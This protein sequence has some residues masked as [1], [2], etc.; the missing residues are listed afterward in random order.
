MLRTFHPLIQQLSRAGWVRHVRQN[1][2][3][4]SVIG[5]ADELEQF[6]FGSSRAALSEAASALSKIQSRKCFYCGESIG[7]GGDVDHFIPWAKYPRDLAHNFVLAHAS[8]NRHKSD[9]LAAEQHLSRW[10]DRN[11]RQGED[12]V[13][14]LRGFVA[15]ASC[16][17]RVARWAYEQAVAAGGYGWLYA[18]KT[19]PLGA[20]CLALLQG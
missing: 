9:I 4:A 16:S 3:N 6:M 14:E 13:A 17:I 1:Q 15:D 20:S 11:E 12:L 2:R 18:K 10:L 5:Q 8:C 7:T 19:E